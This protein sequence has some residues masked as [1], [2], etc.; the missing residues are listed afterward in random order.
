MATLT[1]GIVTRGRPELV[2]WTVRETLSQVRGNTQIV[3]LADHDDDLSG[4][5]FPDCVTVDVRQREDSVGAKWNRMMQIAP[6]DV[7]F[8]MVDYRPQITPGFDAKIVEAASVFPDG[9]GC[10]YQQLANLSFPTYQAITARMAELMGG[11]YVTHFPYWFVDHWLDDI[12]RMIGRFVYA[13]GDTQIGNRKGGTQDFR[14]PGLWAT[15]YDAMYGEREEMAEWLLTHM[16]E[17]SWRKD[18][19]RRNFALVHQRSRLINSIVRNMEGN[20]PFD[21]R[22]LRLRSKA[23]SKLQALYEDMEKAA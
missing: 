21:D 16:D 15:L 4:V 6:A 1:I 17:P 2:Q 12:S 11:F 18:M 7:Y 14:E 3:V 22:Y 19:L 5:D 8:A 10:V 9:I 20:A 13:P 23:A